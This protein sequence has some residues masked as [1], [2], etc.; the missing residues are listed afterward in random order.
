MGCKTKKNGKIQFLWAFFVERNDKTVPEK[1]SDLLYK[2]DKKINESM[3]EWA[4][5][6][7]YKNKILK[8]FSI[9]F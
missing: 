9:N 2:K 8:L 5:I 4:L 6:E 3:Y 1:I 7:K